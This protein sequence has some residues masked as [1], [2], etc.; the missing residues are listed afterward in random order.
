MDLDILHHAA[1][2]MQA[3]VTVLFM[4]VKEKALPSDGWQK[5]KVEAVNQ[6]TI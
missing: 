2:L 6:V 4:Q 1:L 5:W 3:A